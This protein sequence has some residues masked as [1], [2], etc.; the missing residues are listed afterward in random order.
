MRTNLHHLLEQMAHQRSRSPAL[1]F[2]DLTMS[3]AELWRT[4][5]LAAQGLPAMFPSTTSRRR[6]NHPES[7]AGPT[8]SPAR[9]RRAA[10]YL[11]TDHTSHDDHKSRS[12]AIA[13][14]RIFVDEPTDCGISRLCSGFTFGQCQHVP[15]VT[16]KDGA[17]V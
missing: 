6:R 4:T 16:R 13:A 2:R 8:P 14:R 1:T 9:C 15:I 7:P 5:S 12:F 10:R 11:R 3:Y 17:C